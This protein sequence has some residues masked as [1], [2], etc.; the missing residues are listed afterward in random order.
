MAGGVTAAARALVRQPHDW[1]LLGALAGGVAFVGTCLTGHPLLVTEV[2]FPF[3]LQLGFVA[4]LGSSTLLNLDAGTARPSERA[5]SRTRSTLWAAAVIVG[6][7]ALGSLAVRALRDP[8]APPPSQAVDGFYGWETGADGVR[9][10]WSEQYMSLFV[11]GDVVRVDF[12]VRAPKEERGSTPMGVEVSLDGIGRGR[13]LAGDR[14]TT[15]SIDLTPPTPPI[16]VNRINLRVNRTWRPALLIP[17]SADM[18]VVGVQVGEYR[19]L[20]AGTAVT[21]IDR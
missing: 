5:P 11:P 16:D 7:L 1:R 10:R 18:R 3:W 12:P 8:L 17:G 6:V 2:A 4:A 20:R 9:F 13:F 15:I 14:W 19:L 21:R